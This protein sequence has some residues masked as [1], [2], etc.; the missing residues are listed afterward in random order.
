MF[1]DKNNVH[2]ATP[3]TFGILEVGG[4]MCNLLYTREVGGAIL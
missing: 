3:V 1:Q 2:T 4:A